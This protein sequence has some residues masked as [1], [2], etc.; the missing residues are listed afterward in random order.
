MFFTKEHSSFC[1]TD[2]CACLSLSKYLCT[3]CIKALKFSRLLIKFPTILFVHVNCCFSPI[4]CVFIFIVKFKNRKFVYVGLRIHI[5]V[6]SWIYQES[7][8]LGVTWI[9]NVRIKRDPSSCKRD[10]ASPGWL[11]FHMTQT[12]K[13][14][15]IDHNGILSNVISRLRS[16]HRRC[17]LKKGVLRNF[18]KFT[19]KH[20]C[21]RPF[22]NKVAGLRPAAFLKKS[23]WH[24]C[25]H[26]N[27]AKFLRTPFL[28][29][30]SG[31][32]LL[33]VRRDKTSH[34]TSP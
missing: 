6:L 4:P 13:L 11:F 27:F 18:A 23:L 2:Y 7:Y 15:R 28:Q 9:K 16:S 34:R 10:R 33:P 5:I 21:Q 12:W 32:L 26:I 17:S 30:T 1:N 22:F 8:R 24:R 29:N 3:N 20:L 14:H 25:F 19:R 31:R